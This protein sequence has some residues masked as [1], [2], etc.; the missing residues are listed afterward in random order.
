MEN[1]L[2]QIEQGEELENFSSQTKQTNSSS[3][4]WENWQFI[5]K[6]TSWKLVKKEWSKKGVKR[7]KSKNAL[8]CN[9]LGEKPEPGEI[10]EFS[11]VMVTLP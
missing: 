9:L 1:F 6:I 2:S 11:A 3:K 7:R 5:K 8:I 4:Y 10:K